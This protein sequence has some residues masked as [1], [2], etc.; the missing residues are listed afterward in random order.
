M[1]RDVTLTMICPFCGGEHSVDVD[2]DGYAKRTLE[3]VDI[4]R[5]FPYLTATEREQ[6]I[7]SICPDCQK[8]LF[9]NDDEEDEGDDIAECMRESLESTGQWW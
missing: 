2:L 3:G 6:I 5:A 7:S 4:C 1:E 8:Q 9:E